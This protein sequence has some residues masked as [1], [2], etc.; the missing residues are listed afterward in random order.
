MR[1]H[2]DPSSTLLY[3]NHEIEIERDDMTTMFAHYNN[4]NNS[5]QQQQQ[6][7]QQQ[8]P[9]ENS[10]RHS[11][12][13]SFDSNASTSV[14][15]SIDNI[16]STAFTS[17][18]TT[19]VTN[20]NTGTKRR[21]SPSLLCSSYNNNKYDGATRYSNNSSC[22]EESNNITDNDELEFLDCNILQSSLK[23]VRL[24]RCP[25]EFR[26]QRDLI[27]LDPRK[28]QPVNDEGWYSC[29]TATAK[30][31]DYSHTTA[32]SW[33]HSST[34]AR[35]TIVDSL[36]ICL[37]F[38]LPEKQFTAMAIA[39]T[40]MAATT[41]SQNQNQ[42]H[43]HHSYHRD[44]QWRI[45]IQI[46]RMYPHRV[47]VVSRIEGLSVDRIIIN[48]LPPDKQSILLRSSSS[49]TTSTTATTTTT[50]EPS[51]LTQQDQHHHLTNKSQ[52]PTPLVGGG[53]LSGMKTIV[54]DEWSPIIGLGELLDFILEVAAANAIDNNND[55]S[56]TSILAGNNVF[57][58]DQQRISATTKK[59]T[60]TMAAVTRS[61]S[62]C[63][64]SE[65]SA[66]SFS[67]GRRLNNSTDDL[68]FSSGRNNNSN[69]NNNNNTT[70]MMTMI[71]DE[72]NTNGSTTTN[73]INVNDNAVSFLS[74]NRFDVGYEKF[75]E[76][77]FE[78]YNNNPASFA[79]A[80]TSNNHINDKLIASNCYEQSQQQQLHQYREK[81]DDEIDMDIC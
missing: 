56:T 60:T 71:L 49:P 25:G 72:T 62:S 61:S 37:F 39:M 3:Q 58:V 57:T 16:S 50:P 74:P 13:N 43:H 15:A 12:N 44:Y 26:L 11:H 19:S 65:S 28:W 21:A 63:D 29:N 8:R 47:P 53:N 79:V 9:S 52:P 17:S 24:S 7:Q 66:S 51:S 30:D 73:N 35:L 42:H 69:N 64:S 4:N 76:T 18:A 33:I 81:G 5:R 78:K 46:P 1:D 34:N 6:Q 54:W 31:N 59:K 14:M 10:L 80:T 55:T 41:D 20:S 23:R 75:D 70:M 22:G 68:L 77:G 67:Q 27:T 45:M 2:F 32:T 40:T 36:R 48:E 38:P